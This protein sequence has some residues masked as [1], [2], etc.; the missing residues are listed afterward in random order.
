MYQEPITHIQPMAPVLRIH[1][2]AAFD[3]EIYV[4]VT[5]DGITKKTQR[6]GREDPMYCSE[7]L[8]L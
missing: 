6:V 3:G 4:Q 2:L 7:T 5:I 8:L 1:G